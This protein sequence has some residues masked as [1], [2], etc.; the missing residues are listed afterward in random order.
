MIAIIDYDA[1]N[2]FSVMN[3]LRRLNA[4]YILTS[5][6]AIIKKA[7]KVILPGVGHAGA[8]MDELKKR[9]LIE[10]I[11]GITQPVLGICVGMQLMYDFSEEGDT[12]CLGIVPGKIV[13]FKNEPGVKIPHM[14]WNNNQYII[15]SDEGIL[16]NSYEQ[17]TYFVHSYYA[18]VNVYTVAICEYSVQFSSYIRYKWFH[19]VQFHPEK[20]GPVGATIIK[21]FLEL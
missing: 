2:T 11:K 18:P 19:A 13:R 9:N 10:V 1:G 7:D 17:E 20:S 14:G 3:T 4:H 21:N 6:L 15:N 5:D 8:A 12:K 16:K